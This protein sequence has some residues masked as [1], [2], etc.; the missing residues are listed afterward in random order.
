MFRTTDELTKVTTL[1]SV[2]SYKHILQNAWP[3]S[4]INIYIIHKRPK[5]TLRDNWGNTNM[6]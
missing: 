1:S 4:S 6:D 5:T 3:K 2:Y